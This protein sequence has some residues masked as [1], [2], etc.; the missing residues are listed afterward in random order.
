ML[1]IDTNIVV[2]YLTADHPEQS[3]K[4]KALIDSEDIFVRTTVLLE[5]E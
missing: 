5:A 3:P 4:A 1:A 2:L